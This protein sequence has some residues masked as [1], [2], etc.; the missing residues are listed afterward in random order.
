MIPYIN[1]YKSFFLLSWSIFLLYPTWALPVSVYGRFLIYA[2]LIVYF[3]ISGFVASKWLK[4]V[5]VDKPFIIKPQNL[6]VKIKEH[7]EL[8]VICSI[9][10]ILHLFRINMPI[11]NLGDEALHIQGGLWVYDYL[12]RDWHRVLQFIFWIIVGLTFLGINKNIRGTYLQIF[13]TI[14]QKIYTKGFL[15]VLFLFGIL[16]FLLLKD[17]TYNLSLVRYAPVSRLLYLMG[18]LI[19]GITHIAPRIIQLTFYILTTI[20]LYRTINLFYDRK[21]ALLAVPFYLFSPIV[22]HY[23]HLGQLTSGVTF[24]IVLISY[25][26]LRYL[27][28][29]HRRDLILTSFFIG[30]GYLYKEDILLMFFICGSYLILYRLREKNVE[31]KNELK[32]LLISLVPVIPW[33]IIQRFMNWRQ[34]K[35]YWDHLTSNTIFIY[36]QL[37]QIQSWML[38]L[39]FIISIIF[40]LIK[41]RNNLTIYF[42]FL[43]IAFYLFYTVDYT[44]PYKQHRFSVAFYPTIAIFLSQFIIYTI[45]KIKWKHSF[46]VIYFIFTIY[47][48]VL[49][50]NPDL[51]RYV[52]SD[53]TLEFPADRAM[54]W[55][56]DNVKGG[57]KIMILKIMPTMFYCDKFDIDKSKVVFFWYELEGVSTYEG[58]K[59]YSIKNKIKYIMFPYSPDYPKGKGGDVFALF[60]YLKKNP[61]NDFIEMATFNIGNDY[62]FIHMIKNQKE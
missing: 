22:F 42:G 23:A 45:E 55:V 57:E 59:E 54:E 50:T 44:A 20:Y 33:M 17:I 37:F 3:A 8:L 13:N 18:F 7:K 35:I 21:T 32:V 6:S 12:G 43:F 19:G 48:I 4:N 31:I 9:A 11:L 30:F 27:K 36:L 2:G 26:F 62:I 40:I 58:L 53:K 10:V 24:F 15:I 46:K 47:L 49:S 28:D 60:D 56:K 29:R 41:K 61:T 5:S 25:H 34:Y 52:F 14:Y 38:F 1:Q 39:L 51:G 16:Y